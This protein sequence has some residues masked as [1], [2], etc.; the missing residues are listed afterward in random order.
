M[1]PKTMS[2]AN[3]DQCWFLQCNADPDGILYDG[4]G[5]SVECCEIH[6]EVASSRGWERFE[7][8]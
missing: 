3:R 4:D 1:S 2:E 8:F 7:P 6:G 5:A